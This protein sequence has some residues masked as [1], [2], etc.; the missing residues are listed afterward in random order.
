MARP[1][2]N[3]NWEL[4]DSYLLRQCDGVG[5]AGILGISPETL[6]RHCQ[7]DYKIGFDA[8]SAQKKS[9]GKEILRAKQYDTA[10]GDSK[11][12]IPGNVSMQIWLGKQYLG[13]RDKSELTGAEGK[14][15]IPT[16]IFQDI[17]SKEIK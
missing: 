12:S 15:L 9:E 16:I 14:D 8:Y 13:Q 17:S 3:I 11:K 10:V 5:I 1:E 4:V 2:A 6:Y 7:K